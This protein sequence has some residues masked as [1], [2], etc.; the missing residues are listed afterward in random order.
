MAVGGGPVFSLAWDDRRRFLIVGGQAII[1][2]FRADLAE[3]RKTSQ[4]QRSVASGKATSAVLKT[5][6]ASGWGVWSVATV[7]VERGTVC[8]DGVCGACVG[9]GV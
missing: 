8:G 2:V 1:N 5:G 4:Q 9:A 6:A 7:C 3:A